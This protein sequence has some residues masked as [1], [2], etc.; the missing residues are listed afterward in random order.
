MLFHRTVKEL[1]ETEG[2]GRARPLKLKSTE[3]MVEVLTF[4]ST[5][6]LLTITYL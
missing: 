5:A 2:S 1:S 6:N 4:V 3:C